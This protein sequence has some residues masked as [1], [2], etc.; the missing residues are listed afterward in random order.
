MEKRECS[1]IWKE[2]QEKL[3]QDALTE[4]RLFY[5]VRMIIIGLTFSLMAF[6]WKLAFIECITLPVYDIEYLPYTDF[7]SFGKKE[8]HIRREKEITQLVY[9]Y[10]KFKKLVG[11]EKALACVSDGKGEYIC[12]RSWVP[13]YSDRLSYIAYF[14]WYECRINGE[15]VAI[16]EFQENKCEV[17]IYNHIW[18]SIYFTVGHLKTV[19]EYSEYMELLEYIWKDR[20]ASADWEISFVYTDESTILVFNRHL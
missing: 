16:R 12:A 2:F 4:S 6:L 3:K 10:L 19:I 20:A 11:K 7:A 8:L 13:F 17:V 18:R 14:A 1:D 9:F 5:T 15:N